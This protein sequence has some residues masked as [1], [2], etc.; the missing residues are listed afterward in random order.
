MR[1][2]QDYQSLN[3][4]ASGGQSRSFWLNPIAT[5]HGTITL[6]IARFTNRTDSVIEPT[7]LWSNPFI[8]VVIVC[9][10]LAT[11]LGQ[12]LANELKAE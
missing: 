2:D 7:L 9:P 4:K 5:R 10:R 8:A 11:S 3:E 6:Q 12:P 1:L